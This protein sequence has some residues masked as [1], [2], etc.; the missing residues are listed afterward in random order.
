MLVVHRPTGGILPEDSHSTLRSDL[1][2]ERQ[3]EYQSFLQGHAQHSKSL[4]ELRREMQSE[5][6]EEIHQPHGS[7]HLTGPTNTRRHQT[8][9]LGDGRGLSDR[10]AVPYQTRQDRSGELQQIREEER[11]Y[12][13]IFHDPPAPSQRRQWKEDNDEAGAFKSNDDRGRSL[14]WETEDRELLDWAKERGRANGHRDTRNLSSASNSPIPPARGP[15]KSRSLRSISAPVIPPIGIAGLGAYDDAVVKR[16][17]QRAYAEELRQQMRD[18]EKATRHERAKGGLLGG[19]REEVRGRCRDMEVRD[20][21][22]G[23]VART[24]PNRLADRDNRDRDWDKGAHGRSEKERREHER[25]RDGDRS[26]APPARPYYA[27]YPPPGYPNFYPPPPP[28]WGHPHYYYPPPAPPLHPPPS[29]YDD[30]MYPSDRRYPPSHH[31]PP[32][33]NPYHPARRVEFGVGMDRGDKIPREREGRMEVNGRNDYRGERPLSQFEEE[34]FGP[35]AR[36]PTKE[37]GRYDKKKYRAELEEQMRAKKDRDVRA[38]SERERLNLQTEMEVYDPWGRGGCGAPLKDGAGKVMADLK[39]MR[40]VNNDKLLR[41]PSRATPHP[42]LSSSLE[43][44]EGSFS[45]RA[46]LDTIVFDPRKSDDGQKKALQDEYRDFLCRQVEEKEAKKKREKQLKST[47]EQREQERLSAERKKLAADYGKSVDIP[48]RRDEKAQDNGKIT[49]FE[50]AEKRRLEAIRRREEEVKKDA[51]EREEVEARNRALADK[52][53]QPL[54]E[55]R[56]QMR[57]PPVPT[58]A[59][60]LNRGSFGDTNQ[61][62]LGNSNQGSFSDPNQGSFGDPPPRTP[63]PQPR[64]STS[65]PVPALRPRPSHAHSH[66]GARDVLSVPLRS[67][68]PP[69]PALRPPQGT[70][71]VS[72]TRQNDPIVVSGRTSRAPP[73]NPTGTGR[74]QV[75]MQTGPQNGQHSSEDLI[76]NLRELR[77]RLQHEQARNAPPFALPPSSSSSSVHHRPTEDST[78]A[79][80]P[81]HVEP[82]PLRI[83]SDPAIFSNGGRQRPLIAKERSRQ[84]EPRES[85]LSQ[86][87]PPESRLNAANSAI[88]HQGRALIG[89]VEAASNHVAQ[90]RRSERLAAMLSGG[91]ASTTGGIPPQGSR[92]GS[93]TS[94]IP[95]DT[96]HVPLGSA[97]AGNLGAGR[98]APSTGNGSRD[99]TSVGGGRREWS[100]GGRSEFSIATLDVENMARANEDRQRR[101][102]AILNTTGP[103]GHVPT[104]PPTGHHEDIVDEFLNRPRRTTTGGSLVTSEREREGRAPQWRGSEQ[105]LDCDTRHHPAYM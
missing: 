39:V 11:Q 85:S 2:S 58:V 22:G 60:K 52:M 33:H 78:A 43:L 12:R 50:A 37:S 49:K 59:L 66:V 69:V 75:I 8:T 9:Q 29:H 53:A 32:S 102:D 30:S 17:R 101:L 4:A 27:P 90:Q 81:R 71:P 68:S 61:G 98:V 13:G 72:A 44:P 55:L 88:S 82:A 42:P 91:T 25:F 5:R 87:E 3:R 77:R 97:S 14:N 19:A 46:S 80:P 21:E 96:V 40:Q 28:S 35:Q 63:E 89:D 95:S 67:S 41:G 105:S 15:A 56:R 83:P 94:L 7:E 34:E 74:G 84:S 100:A 103:R 6:E 73:P 92:G 10:Q 93:K 24:G 45:P 48:I 31:P 47:E 51:K 79:P 70:A 62:S 65:P 26:E 64:S 36:A 38:K 99:G 23:M 104:A 18:K 1:R 86:S 16:E 54:P 57:S 20:I 76:G